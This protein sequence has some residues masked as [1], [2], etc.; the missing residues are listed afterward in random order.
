M[1]HQNLQ[2]RNDIDAVVGQRVLIVD[3]SNGMLLRSESTEDQVKTHNQIAYNMIR[4]QLIVG[5]G[6]V[7]RVGK[8]ALVNLTEPTDSYIQRQNAL[9]FFKK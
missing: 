4:P 8:Q 5:H 1:K 6:I 7:L 3:S 9:D 2:C